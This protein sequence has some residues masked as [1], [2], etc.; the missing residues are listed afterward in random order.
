[1]NNTTHPAL[2]AEQTLWST[3]WQAIAHSRIWFMSVL[4]ISAFSSVIYPHPPLVAFGAI[5]GTTFKPKRAILIAMLIWLM[6]QVYGYTLRQYP[7]TA[8]SL[9][10]G[11]MMGLGTLIVTMLTSL[12]PPFSQ[13]MLKGHCLWV[14]SIA[15]VGFTAFES[16]ILALDWLLIGSHMLTWA[17]TGSLFAKEVI[18]AIGLLLMHLSFIRFPRLVH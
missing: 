5:A 1:M 10:W 11:S 6:N 3:Q 2:V 15:L 9:L 8:D 12:R 4:A 17:I 13:K 18:W 14:G 16:L 7:W